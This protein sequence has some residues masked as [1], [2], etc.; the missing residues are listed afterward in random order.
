MKAKMIIAAAASMLLAA[1]SPETYSIYLDVRQPSASGMDLSRKSMAIV[2]MDGPSKVDSLLGAMS[3]ASF[4]EAMEKDYF[5][6][7]EAIG[8]YVYPSA[9]TVTV[10]TMRSLIMDTGE[11]VVFLMKSFVGEPVDVSNIPYSK[12]THP[13]SAYVCKARVPMKVNLYVYDSMGLD[14]VKTYHGSTF[15]NAAVFNSGIIPQDNLNDLLKGRVPGIAGES[16]GER[17]SNRFI[18]GWATETFSFYW[19]DDSNAENWLSAI[20]KAQEG[21]FAEAIQGFEPF[22]KSKNKF[23]AAHACYDIAMCFYLLGDLDLSMKWL[24]EADKLENVSRTGS[25]RR[26]IINKLQK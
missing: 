26:R 7:E 11:D 10:E 23:K 5:N 14:T 20:M 13:D 8:T 16:V 1:C 4:A 3:A 17:I 15:A 19:F 6:G 18:G 25:L 24:D 22:A 9:D 12:A 21:K 2:Y